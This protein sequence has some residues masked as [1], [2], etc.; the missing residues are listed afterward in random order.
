MFEDDPVTAKLGFSVVPAYLRQ[1]F[2]HYEYPFLT[3]GPTEV[4]QAST[5]KQIRFVLFW[6][7]TQSVVGI[8]RRRFGAICDP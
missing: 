7:I 6:G 4:F 3:V 8:L 5:A 1:Y 2:K